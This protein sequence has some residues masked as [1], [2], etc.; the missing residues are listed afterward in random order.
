MSAPKMLKVLVASLV[1]FPLLVTLTLVL[2]NPPANRIGEVLEA[3]ALENTAHNVT[4]LH[5][6]ENSVVRLCT[7]CLVAYNY[8]N[9]DGTKI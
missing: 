4:S 5:A 2:Q 6:G 9:R 8:T 1:A 3:S 7:F